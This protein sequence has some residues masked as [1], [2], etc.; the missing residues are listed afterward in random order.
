MIEYWRRK[1]WSCQL[2]WLYWNISIAFFAICTENVQS[3]A[4]SR[5][6]WST[7]WLGSIFGTRPLAARV[8]KMFWENIKQFLCFSLQIIYELVQKLPRGC[9]QIFTAYH[10]RLPA[11]LPTRRLFEGGQFWCFIHQGISTSLLLVSEEW[12]N[13]GLVKHL[14]LSQ[15]S[16]KLD[17]ISW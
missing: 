8:G 4:Q 16:P 14:K 9:S 10:Q 12:T 11:E 13:I 6:R 15:A 2:W 7:H 1:K 3:V 5:L 17:L